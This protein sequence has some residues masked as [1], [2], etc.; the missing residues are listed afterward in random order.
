MLD[1]VVVALGF[2][3]SVHIGH[4]SVIK[5][6]RKIADSNNAKLVV[7]SFSGNLRKAINGEN[8]K[9]IYTDF[10]RESLIKS[11]GADEVFFAPCTK[12]F[13]ALDRSEFL[14]FLNEKFNI[15]AYVC[16]LDYRFGKGALGDVDFLSDYAKEK[17]QILFLEKDC[18]FQG[19]KVSTKGIKSLLYNGEIEKANSLLVDKYS[20]SSI[21][22]SGRK[23]G[24]T[25]GF[26]TINFTIESERQPLK[27]GVYLGHTI[28]DK[29]S[30]K[31][32]INYGNRPT[33]SLD[34]RVVEA[35]ILDF[36]GD[37]YGKKITLVFDKFIRDIFKF[38]DINQLKIQLEKDVALARSIEI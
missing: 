14:S 11:I 9:Y 21:V 8:E 12:E 3:D 37:L 6:A 15:I 24:R 28:I 34:D 32:I 36:E 16:G 33:F 38:D 2:F 10:E 23:V 1:K 31:A 22:K 4:R 20:L 19:N 18:L 26:P 13:L 17:G 35:H 25:M 27:N 30:Y 7:F 5:S 29:K